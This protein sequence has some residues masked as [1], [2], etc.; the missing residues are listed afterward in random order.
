MSYAAAAKPG[1]VASNQHLTSQPPGLANAPLSVAP[2]GDQVSAA[3]IDALEVQIS[4]LSSCFQV[5][6]EHFDVVAKA[7]ASIGQSMEYI[8][9][10]VCLFLHLIS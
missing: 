4:L 6:L 8:I 1:L 2:L 5:F 10:C 3:W 7:V 9:K